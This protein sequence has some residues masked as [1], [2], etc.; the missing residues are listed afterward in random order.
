MSKW[1]SDDGSDNETSSACKRKKLSEGEVIKAK[2]DDRELSHLRTRVKEHNPLIHGC[3]SVYEYES[4]NYI[5]EGTYGMVFKGRCLKTNKIYALKRVKLGTSETSKNENKLGFPI[6]ALREINILLSLSHPNIVAV[7]EMV[8]GSAM[9]QVF[10]VMDFSENDIK[11]CIELSKPNLPF[12]TGEVKCLMQQLLSGVEYLH[13]KWYLHRDLKTSNLLY[14]NRGILTICDFGMAR[15][16]GEPLEIYTFEC[17][18]LWYRA[19]EVLLG[20]RKYSTS[21]DMW[22]VGC[23]F[24]E[25]CLG[26]PLFCGSGEVDQINLIFRILGAPS[27]EKWPGFSELP[28]SKNINW[29]SSSTGRLRETMTANKFSSKLHLSSS[30]YDL[31]V[32]LLEM[33][34]SKRISASDALEHVWFTEDPKP[35][36]HHMMP[37]FRDKNE[38][39]VPDDYPH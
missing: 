32:K 5:D 16:Y 35:T 1:D 30:G 4:L 31:L 8:V 37:L 27:D 26:S 38:V 14:S 2:N 9:N 24:A 3:R 28:N 23:I 33:D 21:L 20:S 18:T 19:P 15:K 17:V 39:P 11:S 13:S 36:Q 12:S 7:K 29:R 25:L 34:P 10:M 6:T 22:S